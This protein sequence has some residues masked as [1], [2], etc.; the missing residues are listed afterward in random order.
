MTQ[1]GETCSYTY[2]DVGNILT[3]TRNGVTTSYVYDNLGQLTRVNDPSDTTSGTTWVYDYDRGGNIL[4]KKRYAYTTG[5]L[6]TVLQ[7]ISYTYG[8]S[9]WKDK[10]TAYNGTGISYDAIGNPIYD[11]TWT[12]TWKAGKQLASV[13]KSGTTVNYTYNASD[14]RIGKTVNGVQTNYFTHNG[15]IMH[16]ICGSNTLHF[17]YDATAKPAIVEFNGENYAY[18]YNLQNDVIAL[19]DKNGSLVVRYV[20]DA[21]GKMLSKSGS[22]ASSLGAIQ[23]FRYRGYVFDEETELYYLGSRYYNPTWQR[24]L[25]I[26][27]IVA[28]V[29]NAIGNNLFC[30]CLNNP[31]CAYDPDGGWFDWLVKAVAV[32]AVVAVA[33]VAAVA[34]VPAVSAAACTVAATMTYYG[35]SAA[36]A[37]VASEA[38]AG[39]AFAVGTLTLADE[40]CDVVTGHSVIRDDLLDGDEAAYQNVQMFGS[41]CRAGVNIAAACS[42]GTCFIAGTPVLSENG[43]VAIESIQIGDL[44]WAEDPETGKKSLEPVK[45]IFVKQTDVLV[46]LLIDDE[47]IVTT[48]THPFYVPNIGWV[49][50]QD[51]KPGCELL[52]YSGEKVQLQDKHTEELEEPCTVYNFE[53]DDY[54]TYFVGQQSILVH[55]HCQAW[56][57]ERRRYWRS[58]GQRYKDSINET[59]LSESGT[60]YLGRENIRRMSSGLAPIG[61]DGYSVSLHHNVGISNSFTDYGEILTTAHRS[62]YKLLHPWVFLNK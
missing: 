55:N 43:L 44:V 59:K 14:E 7:T 28:T 51:L 56:N 32:V 53:V 33:A 36:V 10:M 11:G 22:M 57:R 30:Y 26:D 42:P 18:I 27:Y 49:R 12:Y 61:T 62:N 25:G 37:T 41:F 2:D 31:V 47:E 48:P 5:S 39:T 58:Q 8:D 20:Y 4:S 38:I 13:S 50:A 29:G 6:G 17:K 16:M 24:F 19:V 9:N 45:Q 54:H 1:S 15:K 3:A 21:W 34:L 40:V 23:P 52:L 46:H 35:A 60:Y